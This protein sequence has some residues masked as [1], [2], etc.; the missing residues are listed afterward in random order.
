MSLIAQQSIQTELPLLPHLRLLIDTRNVGT[1]GLLL[2]RLQLFHLS[3]SISEPT[4]E[5]TAVDR[6]ISEQAV[7]DKNSDRIDVF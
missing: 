7:V 4:V 6:Y 3:C 2:S 1:S 5:E